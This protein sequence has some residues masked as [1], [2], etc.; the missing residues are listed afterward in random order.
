MI[1]FYGKD[2]ECGISS[3][4][5]FIVGPANDGE[6]NPVGVWP[7]MSTIGFYNGEEWIHKCGAT[8]ISNNKFITAAHCINAS[9]PK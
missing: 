3:D 8:L 7:W 9:E 6:K 2:D 1:F 5:N 4:T